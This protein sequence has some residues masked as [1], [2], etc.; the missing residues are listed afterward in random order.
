M[1]IKFLLIIPAFLLL[2]VACADQ[3]KPKD[4]IQEDAYINLLA[5][6]HI[7]NAIE[8]TYPDSTLR[9]ESLERVLQKY[10]LSIETF[11]QSHEYYLQDLDAQYQRLQTAN[12]RMQKEYDRINEISREKAEQKRKARSEGNKYVDEDEEEEP[13]KETP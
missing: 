13:A 1:R 3:N 6:L 9:D 2:F 7:L 8:Q 10:N 5:E 12:D 4:L 11:E